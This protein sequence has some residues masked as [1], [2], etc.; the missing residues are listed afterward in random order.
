MEGKYVQNASDILTLLFLQNGVN[1][2]TKLS[3]PGASNALATY[4]AYATSESMNNLS[5]FKDQM[6]TLKLTTTDLFVRGKIA[7]II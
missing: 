2:Y 6:D 7:A 5:Q 1:S 3:Q 4:N